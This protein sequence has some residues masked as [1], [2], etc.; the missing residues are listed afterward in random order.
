[1]PEGTPEPQCPSCEFN[2]PETFY[3]GKEL[4]TENACRK[5]V[6]TY[7]NATNCVY[8]ERAPGAD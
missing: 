6:T 2:I 3:L 8:Y 4:R 7:P 5:R 1:M